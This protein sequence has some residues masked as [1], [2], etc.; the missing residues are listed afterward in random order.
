MSR[1]MDNLVASRSEKQPR[2]PGAL[3][4]WTPGSAAARGAGL[5][6]RRGTCTEPVSS[7]TP[8]GVARQSQRAFYLFIA[9]ALLLG[10]LVLLAMYI[11]RGL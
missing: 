9:G 8:E 4:I 11:G 1:D 7:D 10:F 3:G 6:R 2:L 5:P